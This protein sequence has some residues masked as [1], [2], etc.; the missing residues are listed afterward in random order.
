MTDIRKVLSPLATPSLVGTTNFV[1][2][3]ESDRPVYYNRAGFLDTD[4][5]PVLSGVK[6][7]AVTSVAEARLASGSQIVSG[8]YF[9]A[10]NVTLDPS[11]LDLRKL[12]IRVDSQAA[13]R[14]WTFP[15]PAD[16]VTYLKSQF[17][18][19]N[20][21][22]GLTWNI[23]FNND[24]GGGFGIVLRVT[25]PLAPQTV[26]T[27]GFTGAG[28]FDRTVNAKTTTKVYFVLNN[29]TPGSES[30]AYYAVN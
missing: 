29:V 14:T 26:T 21:V 24:N 6:E 18:P 27:Y 23:I 11:V 25:T 1:K 13:A 28:P 5:H 9:S 16:L 30:V 8:T 20:I 19:E 2:A 15:T 3:P 17:G 12:M 7:T 10:G 4:F 22:A